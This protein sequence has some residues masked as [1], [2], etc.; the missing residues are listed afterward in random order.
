M[1]CDECKSRKATVHMTKIIQG[2]KEEIHLCEECAKTMETLNLE[3]SFSIHNFLA[4]LLDMNQDPQLKHHYKEILQC[5]QCGTSYEGFRQMGR[6]SCDQC[7][8][9]FKEKL[10]PLIRKVHGNLHH[11]GKVPKRRGGIIRLKRE[12]NQLK[13]QLKDAIEEQA[14]ERAANL[15]DQ[16]KDLQDKIE[17]M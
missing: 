11:T 15:R 13:L 7:Y 5:N 16:I 17:E 10:K 14:F 1:T 8:K 4:G 9:N 6:L 2:K 12:V 3:N